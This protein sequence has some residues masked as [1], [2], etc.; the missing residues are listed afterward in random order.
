MRMQQTTSRN[1]LKPTSYLS[2][3]GSISRHQFCVM[4]LT[5]ISVAVVVENFRHTMVLELRRQSLDFEDKLGALVDARRGGL[6]PDID[7]SSS[8][9]TNNRK[10][11]GSE[12]KIILIRSVGNPLPPRHHPLQAYR[13]L[14]FILL[15]EPEYPFLQKAWLLN[16]IADPTLLQNLTRLLESYNQTYK[17]IPF[18]L[19]EYDQLKYNY[20]RW[21]P[22][23]DFIHRMEY[24]VDKNPITTRFVNEAI[25]NDKS[26][27]VTN[28]NAAR[29]FMIDMGKESSAEWILPWDGNSFLHPQAYKKLYSDL[30]ALPKDQKYAISPMNRASDNSAV[31]TGDYNPVRVSEEP[32][33]ILHRSAKARFH[34]L[35]RYGR[36]NKVEFLQ[37]LKVVDKWAQGVNYYRWEMDILGRVLQ[38]VPD[39][40][41][42][43]PEVGWVTRL[44]S[45]VKILE[46]KVAA[47]LRGKSRLTGLA[48]LMGN[49]DARAVMELHGYRPGQLIFYDEDALARDRQLYNEGSPLIKPLVNELI[50]FAEKALEAGPWSVTQKP[51]ESCAASGNKHDYYTQSPFYWPPEAGE[52]LVWQHREGKSYPGTV[53][54]D[55]E[56]HHFDR[57]RLKDMQYNT[58]ILALAYVMTG[59]KQYGHIAARNIRTWFLDNVTSMSPHMKFAS[60]RP[61]TRNDTGWAAGIMEMKDIYFVLDA[62]RLLERSKFLTMKEQRKLRLW[63]E[64]YFEW[65]E[66]S[67]EGKEEYSES[68]TAHGIFFDVQIGSIAS[69]INDTAKMIWYL[70]RAQCRLKPLLD[71][72]HTKARSHQLQLAL[73]GWSTLARIAESIDLHAWKW[74]LHNHFNRSSLCL[75]LKSGIEAASRMEA[76]ELEPWLPL[77]HDEL[78]YCRHLRAVEEHRLIDDEN[79]NVKLGVAYKKPSMADAYIHG[80]APFWNLGLRHSIIR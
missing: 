61:G 59:E 76:E 56:S 13:N 48:I 64:K 9:P 14:E 41:R 24:L 47:Q 50:E 42:P 70:D 37:R 36:K 5:L 60:V 19:S 2:N 79:I 52:G 39:L 40:K 63:F 62:V 8:F 57:T 21:Q 46:S 12:M 45:G 58:T 49:L 27:Y 22:K 43:A 73:Q 54:H 68:K 7:L 16:R 32:Q 75:A 69:Y 25:N 30:L 6:Q 65:L 33:V 80:V 3:M 29:N 1:Y 77:I 35:L 78:F 23:E 53:I 71:S 74:T 20:T 17:V 4:I 31:L 34:P 55:P 18:N 66:T 44:S 72:V 67:W 11:L 26:L 10:V 28:Q 15:H 51:D 38:P